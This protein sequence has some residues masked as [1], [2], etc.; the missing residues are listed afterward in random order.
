MIFAPVFLILAI[1]LIMIY[2]NPSTRG[3]RWRMDRS[4][5]RDGQTYYHCAACGAEEWVEGTTPPK[6]CVAKRK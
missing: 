3:C 5:N 6:I 2:S 4:R 1:V